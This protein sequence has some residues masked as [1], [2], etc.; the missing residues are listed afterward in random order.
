MDL[1]QFIPEQLF[2]VVSAIYVLGYF[3][4]QSKLPDKYIPITLLMVAIISCPL[5]MRELRIEYILQGVLCWGVAVG[6]NQTLKQL[7]K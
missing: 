3:C 1:I 6:I 4:K 5:I 7:H 2:I